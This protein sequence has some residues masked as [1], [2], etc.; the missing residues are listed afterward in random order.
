MDLTRNIGRW[1]ACF[2]L[3][4]AVVALTAAIIARHMAGGEYYATPVC[5]SGET[6]G[7]GAAHEASV[8]DRC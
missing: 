4:A 7:A 2:V 1:T 8:A 3:T 6:V 5:V